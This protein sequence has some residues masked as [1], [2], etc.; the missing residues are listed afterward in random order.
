M[1]LKHTLTAWLIAAS[2][3]FTSCNVGPNSSGPR[4]GKGTF[5]DLGFIPAAV[6]AGSSGFDFQSAI[7]DNDRVFVATSD[8]IWMNDITNKEWSRSGLDG[9]VVTM[10]YKHPAIANRFFA[11]TQ[12]NGTADDKTFYISS[13][14]G[15]TWEAATN[16]IFDEAN[17]KYETYVCLAARPEHPDHI[18]ANLEGGTMIAVSTDGGLNWVRMNSATESYFGYAC[19]IT[20]M[21]GRADHIYQG[22]ESPLDDAWLGKY[23]VDADNPATLSD[24][25]KIV[26][27]SVLGNRRPNELQAFDFVPNTLYAGLEGALY[28]VTATTNMPIFQSADNNFPYSY[29]KALLVDRYNT[30][31]LLFGGALNDSSQPMSLYETYDEGKSI[32]RID[33]KLGLNNPQVIEI[34]STN[35]SSAAIVLNDQ[36]ANKVKLVLYTQYLPD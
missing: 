12:S 18:Y 29:I 21:P 16:V 32:A 6:S 2:V 25:E 5:D 22:A 27:M 28:K 10:I 17:N 33:N 15:E 8:G 13:N 3:G 14:G 26:D 1:T 19:N 7:Y 4:A 31:H 11:G 30:K 24:F 23:H 34:M 9:K 36:D 35:N 20:F